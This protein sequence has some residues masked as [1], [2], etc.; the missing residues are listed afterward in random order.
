MSGLFRNNS[1]ANG[2]VTFTIK[3]HFFAK[4]PVI[5]FTTH[6]VDCL[7]KKTT[8]QGLNSGEAGVADFIVTLQNGTEVAVKHYVKK[9]EVFRFD[10]D[11]TGVEKVCTLGTVCTDIDP[12]CHG[13]GAEES[14][15]DADNVVWHKQDKWRIV[16]GISA[17]L[18]FFVVVG[19]AIMIYRRRRTGKK[20]NK[21]GGRKPAKSDGEDIPMTRNDGYLD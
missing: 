11:Y 21:F 12:A 20:N 10:L 9:D 13:F 18:L 14:G 16:L 15:T 8:I 5:E 1:I 19:V 6:S 2:R 3:D 17:G 4:S 7:L